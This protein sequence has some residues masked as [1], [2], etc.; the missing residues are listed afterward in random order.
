MIGW[1]AV[2]ARGEWGVEG[3]EMEGERERRG[4][5]GGWKESVRAC[6]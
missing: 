6:V 4:G 1:V 3:I 2:G 5:G